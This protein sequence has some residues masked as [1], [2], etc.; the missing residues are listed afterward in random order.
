ME[1]LRRHKIEKLP[2]VDDN[3]NLMGLITIKDIE[4]S[5]KYPHSAKD[6]KGR[7]LAA[8]AVGTAK[9]YYGARGC[10]KKQESMC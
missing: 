5:H 9:R 6:E 3:Y 1:I 7:L 8:A 4:K 10:L 2:L